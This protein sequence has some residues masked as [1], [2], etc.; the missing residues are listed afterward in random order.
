M[1]KYFAILAIIILPFF[2][3]AQ[4]GKYEEVVYL[5]NGNIYHGVIIEQIPGVSLKIKSS[6][7][8]CVQCKN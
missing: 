5:K 4:L 2:A 7:Q 3:K 1:K 8:K 6:D